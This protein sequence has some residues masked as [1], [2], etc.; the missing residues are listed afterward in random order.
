MKKFKL[1]LMPFFHL[2]PAEGERGTS[3][4]ADRRCRFPHEVDAMRFR[5]DQASQNAQ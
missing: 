2:C 1:W 3:Q 4:A 5:T